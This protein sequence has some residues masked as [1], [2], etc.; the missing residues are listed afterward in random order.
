MRKTIFLT[1]ALVLGAGL[2]APGAWAD[3]TFND[4]GGPGTTLVQPYTGTQVSTWNGGNLIDV[5]ANSGD[6]NFTTAGAQ[7]I[8]ST[9]QLIITSNWNP[10]ITPYPYMHATTADLFVTSG[11]NQWAISLSNTTL[12]STEAAVFTTFSVNTTQSIFSGYSG[13]AYAGMYQSNGVL[14]EIPATASGNSLIGLIPIQW[15]GTTVGNRGVTINLGVLPG[16]NANN[17]SF[18]WAGATCGNDTIYGQVPIPPSAVLLGSGLL[19]ISLLGWRR[20]KKG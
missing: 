5:I 18:L 7:F 6:P 9:N 3:Y 2:L 12:S 11:S 20:R 8:S 15:W 4:S 16:F 1:V 17:F 19:G 10:G 14:H 13:I